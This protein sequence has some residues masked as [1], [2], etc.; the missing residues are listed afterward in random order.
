MANNATTRFPSAIVLLV[1]VA[2]GHLDTL[3]WLPQART[4]H[5]QRHSAA[6][7][8]SSS[9]AV[10]AGVTEGTENDNKTRLRFAGDLTFDSEPLA[11]SKPDMNSYLTTNECRK[12]LLGAGG[13]RSVES[14]PPSPGLQTMWTNQLASGFAQRLPE[15]PDE[16]LRTDTAIHFPGLTLTN[17]VVNGFSIVEKSVDETRLSSEESTEYACASLLI[18]ETRTVIGRKPLVWLFNKL[19]GDGGANNKKDG[20]ESYSDPKAKVVTHTFVAEHNNSDNLVFRINVRFEV[21]V[22][23][24]KRLLRIL[25]ASQSTMEAKGSAAIQKAMSKDFSAAT[26]SV[27]NGYIKQQQQR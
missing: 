1:A 10:E 2:I 6:T 19:T 14:L 17:T 23:F 4:L 18:G 9:S 27:R 24:P 15:V 8:L 25:P 21:I 3:A 5:H 16:F 13:S 20:E 11:A 26:K 12:L 22:E 7:F